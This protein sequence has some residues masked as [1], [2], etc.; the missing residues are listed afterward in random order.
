MCA[1]FHDELPPPERSWCP[2]MAEPAESL[3]QL[4]HVVPAG[5]P[6]KTRPNESEPVRMSCVLGVS[7]R[8]FTGR[9]FSLSANSL[10]TEFRSRWISPWRSATFHAMSA[11]FALY[12]GPLP[13]RSRAL[14]GG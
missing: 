5:V 12:H 6:N 10:L 1:A 7:P 11:P 14:M 3:A 4:L 13:M 9:P 2:S 8:P